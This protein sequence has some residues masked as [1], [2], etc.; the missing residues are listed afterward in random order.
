MSTPLWRRDGTGHYLCN[1]C[2]L[3]HKMNGVNRPLVKPQRRST[4]GG[5]STTSPVP[6]LGS[7]RLG[8]QCANCSTTTTTLWRRNNEGEPVCNACG[9]Y[10]KLHQVARP[11]SMKKDG[12][13]TR[14]RK[15]KG[16]GKSKSKHKQ[17]NSSS[18]MIDKVSM[19]GS[20]PPLPLH[21][22]LGPS[23]N[24]TDGYVLNN[25]HSLMKDEHG[26]DRAPGTLQALLAGS[27]FGGFSAAS[28]QGGLP[29]P[30]VS[31]SRMH[32]SAA[33]YSSIASRALQQ[34]S[35]DLSSHHQAAAPLHEYTAYKQEPGLPTDVMHGLPSVSF[36]GS[37]IIP[38]SMPSSVAPSLL[39]GAPSPPKAIPVPVETSAYKQEDLL[40]GMQ[41]RDGLGREASPN[42]LTP[43]GNTAT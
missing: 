19:P 33:S 31:S 26:Q 17:D 37:S 28:M 3:Y 6:N 8:L 29:P 15:P 22:S 23:L 32:V 30:L 21:S 11:I 34:T 10:Y 9:L 39:Y 1:A 20:V 27:H 4:G 24:P 35:H 25:P 2:G 36:G 41:A 43:L 16:S 14:K 5:S 12:I 38:G 40:V 42:S 13:Q 18:G 7:R